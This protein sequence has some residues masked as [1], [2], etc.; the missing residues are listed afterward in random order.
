MKSKS[1]GF[2]IFPNPKSR[3]LFPKWWH[4]LL[5]WRKK[6]RWYTKRVFRTLEEMTK[7]GIKDAEG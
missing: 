6:D 3:Y 5:F 1:V 4:K 7:L 2:D